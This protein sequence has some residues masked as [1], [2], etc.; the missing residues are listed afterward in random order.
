[1]IVHRVFEQEGVPKEET[2]A[3]NG[4]FHLKKNSRNCKKRNAM[5]TWALDQG[6]RGP[7]GKC[8]I[9]DE[10]LGKKE[11]RWKNKQVRGGSET[12]VC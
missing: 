5:S 10:V 2:G 7:P 8:G 1:L 11:G 4:P 12:E 3:K 6:G 9:H